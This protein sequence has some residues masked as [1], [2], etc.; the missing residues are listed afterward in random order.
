MG[1][2]FKYIIWR[3]GIRKTSHIS[4][5]ASASG[6]DMKFH[7]VVAQWLDLGGPLF[8]IVQNLYLVPRKGLPYH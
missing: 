2:Y 7:P 6:V 8:A 4:F 5:S 3:G 1:A